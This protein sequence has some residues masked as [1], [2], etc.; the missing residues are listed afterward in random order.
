MTLT[1]P[2]DEEKLKDSTPSGFKDWTL[3]KCWTFLRDWDANEDA[4]AEQAALAITCEE[5]GISY[6]D[7]EW[8]GIIEAVKKVE[9]KL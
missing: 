8:M 1:I 4:H 9:G 3:G 2:S 5:Y 7:T 6:M